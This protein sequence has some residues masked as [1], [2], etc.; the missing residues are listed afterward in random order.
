[1]ATTV[2]AGSLEMGMYPVPFAARLLAT[3]PDR[4]RAWI[5][6]SPNSR[7]Q[8]ILVREYPRVGGHAVIGFLGLVEGAFVRHFLAL[9]YSPQTIRKVAVRLKEE[10]GTDHPFAMNTRFRA[11]GKR[12]FQEVID[13]EGER[14]I[15]NVMNDQFELADVIE[16]SLFDQIFYMN[17]LAA[18]WTPLAKF[19][20][21][22]VN[23]RRAF[24]RP[25]IKDKWVP[26]ETLY[27]A[28]L[29]EGDID[30]VADAYRVTPDEVRSAIG[31]E[32]ELRSLAIH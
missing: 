29:A 23:P 15:W 16:P 11:D 30:E 21:V 18:A 20:N 25:A 27:D 9:G 14:K 22:I 5:E 2:L 3:K 12:V 31:F 4:V 6:G 28:Y 13:D 10:H 32:Q 8:P 7:A 26:T 17:D 24:G 1:M 19:A